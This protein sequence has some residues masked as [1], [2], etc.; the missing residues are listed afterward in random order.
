MRVDS[1]KAVRSDM[2]TSIYLKEGRRRKEMRKEER[3]GVGIELL[4]PEACMLPSRAREGM[5]V[6]PFIKARKNCSD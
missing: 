6:S 4:Y 1:I 5:T 2:R 3:E